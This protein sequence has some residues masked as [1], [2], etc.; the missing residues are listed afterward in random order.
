MELMSGTISEAKNQRLGRSWDLEGNIVINCL[1]MTYC[2][3]SI[4]ASLTLSTH[5]REFLFAVD[6]EQHRVHTG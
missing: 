4:S 5:I 6:V 2:Y 3:P 1:L